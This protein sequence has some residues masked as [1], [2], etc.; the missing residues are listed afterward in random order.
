[1][2][3]KVINIYGSP[4]VGKSTTAAGLY[5]KMKSLDYDVELVRE[6]CKKWGYTKKKIRKVDQVY[7][8]N[9]QL[10]EEQDL[11]GT[12]QY[13]ITDSP[14]HLASFYMEHN[15]KKT[16]LTD[17]VNDYLNEIK[18]AT[19]SYNFFLEPGKKYNSTG[20]LE[21]QEQAIVIDAKLKLY[22]FNNN[23]NFLAID[24]VDQIYN[25]MTLYTG[26]LE[27]PK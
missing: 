19:E 14:L 13:L 23:V 6:F 15:F 17:A 4:G 21:T 10:N 1:M 2:K 3:T 26:G 27:C 5:Y 11:Y 24:N 20:R 25:Y 22:L 12:V 16:Y 9:K 7:F 8:F 18:N